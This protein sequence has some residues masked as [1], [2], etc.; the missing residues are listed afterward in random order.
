MVRRA[1][2]IIRAA[3]GITLVKRVNASKLTVPDVTSVDFD[4]ELE[5]DLLE[6]TEAQ[7]EEVESDGSVIADAPLYSRITSFRLHAMLVAG[8]QTYVRWILYKKPDGESLLSNMVSQWHS[9]DDSQ[10]QREIRKNTIAKGL[11]NISSNRLSANIPIR[12]SS[13]ALRRISPLREGDKIT[14]VVAKAADGTT[15]DLSIWGDIRIKANA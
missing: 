10:N 2:P 6:C 12:V 13:G 8:A 14:L 7:D 1:R 4:N 9:S 3:T 11:L 15:A 5:V